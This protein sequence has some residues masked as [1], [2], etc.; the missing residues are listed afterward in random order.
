MKI[1]LSPMGTAGDIRPFVAL[2]VSL[3]KHGSDVQMVVPQNGEEL[4]RKFGIPYR[5]LDFDYRELVRIIASKP[6]LSAITKMLD[7]EISSPFQVLKDI[8]A[9]GDFIIGSARN[10]AASSIAELYGI[11]YYQVWHTPQVFKS[12][13]HTPW[14]FTGQD[15]PPW[16]NALLW[17]I[18]DQ[19][20]NRVGK[21]F[22]DKNRRSLGLKPIKDYAALTRENVLL[23]ADRALAPVPEDVKDSFVHVDYW[24]LY[25]TEELEPRIMEFVQSG[26]KPIFFGFGSMGD[27]N[28]DQTV[29]VIEHIVEKLGIRAVVQK[30]WADLGKKSSS[31]RVLVIDGAPHHKLF[32]HMAA[33]VHHGGAGTL[34]TAALAGIPQI[35]IPQYGDQFY[36]GERAR[37]LGIGPA[38]VPKPKLNAERL[39]KAVV[40][41][42]KNAEIPKRAR[43]VA[44]ILKQRE[45]M[46]RSAIELHKRIL[47]KISTWADRC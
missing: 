35:I 14:R 4:C 46:D 29:E 5:L 16:L 44:N 38:P 17:R 6:S 28:G 12:R 32:P 43:E 37:S 34:H 39:E 9:K 33:A 27:N 22:V 15:N 7:R 3:I 1:I 30:G 8:A 19:K 18:N 10:Y 24:N 20:E 47:E 26:S 2:G 21:R 45:A 11:P 42:V 13:G 41:G 31:S 36:W 23:V 40:Q 25:E